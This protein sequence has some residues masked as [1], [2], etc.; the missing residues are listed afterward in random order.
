MAITLDATRNGCTTMSTSRVMA[1]GASLVCRVLNTRWPVQR[2]LDGDLGRLVVADLADEDDVGRL[3][4]H[5][6]DDAGE[7]Q[8]DLVLHL[9]LV[10]P[11]Q[12]I[13]DGVL[14][15]DDL[16]VGPVQLVEAPRT[17]WSSCPSRS[18]R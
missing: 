7:V 8:A 4:Q 17:A 14:G 10:D 16:A 5:G 1:L 12:V 13:L 18:A 9:H 2:R 15:R 3:P 11:G 6:A